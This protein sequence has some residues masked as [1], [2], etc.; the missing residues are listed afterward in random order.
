MTDVFSDKLAAWR[1]HVNTPWGRIRYAVVGEVIARQVRDLGER[2]RILDVGGGDG[3]DSLPLALA[4]HDVTIVDPSLAWLQEAQRRAAEAGVGVVTVEA[5]LDDLPDGQW[6]LV[7]CHLVLRYRSAEADDLAALASRIRP[8]GRLSV[9]DVNP[10]GRVI[11]EVVTA[12][13]D[14]ALSELHAERAA[15]ITFGT[16]A[17]KIDIDEIIGDAEGAGLTTVGV[18]GYRTANDLLVDDRPKHDPGYFQRL[19]ALELELCDR[20]PFNR[21]GHGWQVVFERPALSDAGTCS[22]ATSTR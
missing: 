22:V 3:R 14:A 6:D 10:A 9:V 7:L 2:L 17:R 8:G 13:P 21:V 20:E 18:F 1:D 16:D 12:G 5:G 15:V 19:L 4:G 11:R